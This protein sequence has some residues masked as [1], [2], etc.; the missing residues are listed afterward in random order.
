[1]EQKEIEKFASL[2]L[3]AKRDRALLCGREKI[4]LSVFDRPTYITDFL[5]LEA[6]DLELWNRH[7]GQFQ[8]QF[9]YNCALRSLLSF[10]ILSS[11]PIYAVCIVRR[12]DDLGRIV[13]KGGV[14]LFLGLSH[15]R[16]QHCLDKRT[17]YRT[18]SPVDKRGSSPDADRR[19]RGA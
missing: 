5:K 3:C 2:Y 6:Y 8:E 1:M 19:F 12:T 14:C 4:T 17:I 7:A 9:Y 10:D 15:Q 11:A 18:L 16:F 13:T